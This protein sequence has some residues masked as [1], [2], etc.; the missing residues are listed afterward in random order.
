[1]PK[2]EPVCAG[3]TM[4]ASLLAHRMQT[5]W[6][7]KTGI[8]RPDF[9]GSLTQASTV[10]LGVGAKGEVHI[11]F[12]SLLPMVKPVDFELDGWDISSMHVGDAMKRGAVLDIDLQK[13]LYEPLSKIVPRPSIYFPDFIAANQESRA[14][15]VLTGSKQEQMERIRADIRDFKASKGL[16]KVIVLWTANTERFCDVRE[17]LNDT[18]DNLLA[19]IQED[20][21]E[22]SPSTCFA[23]ASILEGV[24]YI[25]GSP[26]NTFVPG[27]IELAER[28]GA[29]IAGDDFKSGQVCSQL[30]HE[31]APGRPAA[32]THTHTL[33]HAF[34]PYT[35]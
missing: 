4:V 6:E 8:H 10:K 5:T 11:P 29:F 2:F 22:V 31:R 15:N 21:P 13:Q 26:Q 25:N 28:H 17:G 32:L 34:A 20:E 23:V 9:F 24:T 1:M 7:T 19:A 3:S 12:N 16:D 14:D 33:M 27:V 30:A 18:A 35:D